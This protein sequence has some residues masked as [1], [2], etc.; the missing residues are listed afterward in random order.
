M[1]SLTKIETV[2]FAARMSRTST[3]DLSRA[4]KKKKKGSSFSYLS[5]YL[6]RTLCVCACV[7]VQSY[8][9][10]LIEKQTGRQ[11]QLTPDKFKQT[12]TPRPPCIIS[13]T[14]CQGCF[15]YFYFFGLIF[16][17]LTRDCREAEVTR[18]HPYVSTG[19]FGKVLKCKR[20]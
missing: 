17:T 3:A 6:S 9:G 8:N 2:Y 15:F 12:S 18:R 13:L 11:P 5:L 1:F 20:N 14:E 4:K 16:V 19:N 7:C 10:L